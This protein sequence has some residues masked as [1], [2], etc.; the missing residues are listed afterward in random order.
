MQSAAALATGYVINPY[1][2][3]VPE[4]RVIRGEL[5]YHEDRIPVA[6]SYRDDPIGHMHRRKMIDDVRFRAARH[7]QETSEALGI[8]TGRSPSDLREWVDGGRMPANGVT[9]RQRAAALQIVHWRRLVGEAGYA[10]LE[11]VL[12]KKL[13][14]REIPITDNRSPGKLSTLAGRELRRALDIIAK[15]IRLTS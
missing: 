3:K 10:V 14:L 13:R 9:D 8:G 4:L 15:D 5:A 11:A 12:I 6:I 1:R 2:V 7:Y